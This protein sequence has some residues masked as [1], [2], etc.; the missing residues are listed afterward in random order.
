MKK[1][2]FL[3]LFFG[4]ISCNNT[5]YI[6]AEDALDAAREFKSACLTGEI[7]KALFY[8]TKTE[9]TKNKINNIFNSY[10]LLSSNEKKA[11]K[12]ASII[13]HSSK[14]IQS[15]YQFII[16]TH[17]SEKLDT[18]YIVNQDNYWLVDFKK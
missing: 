13:I 6:S 7:Q 18:L 10:D 15:Q 3:I 2:V 5:E 8:A 14:E 9:Q 16:S 11:L 1:I 4:F 12:T 17:L